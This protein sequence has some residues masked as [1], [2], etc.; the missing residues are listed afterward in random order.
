MNNSL[1]LFFTFL[2]RDF[3]V[4]RKHVKEYLIN[5]SI[6]YP[7]ICTFS[8][9]YLQT[10]LF[11]GGQ[12]VTTIIVGN[13]LL[14]LMVL[15]Y[16]INIKLLFD[17]NA[18]RFIDYQITML[19]PRLVLLERI[20]FTAL[21]TTAIL[22]PFYPIAKLLLQDSFNTSHASW[23]QLGCMLF[24]SALMCSAY[25]MFV[26]CLFK[27]PADTAHLWP[28]LNDPLL[29]LGGFWVPLYFIAQLSPTASFI[30]LLNPMMYVTEGLRYAVIGSSH[31]LPFTTCSLA[32]LTF[33]A[34]FTV[35]AWILFKKRTDHI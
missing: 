19:N 33:S 31:F 12:Q 1:A 32:L 20:L 24:L 23:P 28:R 4:Q 3:Y 14:M 9:G 7:L 21:L 30:A 17:L 26:A 6:L 10:N 27:K 34:L 29:I 35:L 13:A 16:K 8:F 5:Y 2:Q 25:H 11:F 18:D 15:T 22:V